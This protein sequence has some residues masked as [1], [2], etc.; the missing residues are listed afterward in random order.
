MD[1][2]PLITENKELFK[3]IYGLIVSIICIIIVLKTDRLFRLSLHNGI[4][5]FRNAFLFFGIAFFFRFILGA[6][7]FDNINVSYTSIIDLLF[8]FFLIMAG[9]F[10][11][12]SL[13]WKRFAREENK[14]PSSL[15]TPIVITFYSISILLSIADTLWQTYLFMFFSQIFLFGFTTIIS[16]INYINGKKEHKFLKFYL[17][18]MFLSLVAWILNALASIYFLWNPIVLINIYII[19][20][21]I[22]LLFLF[23]VVK[24]TRVKK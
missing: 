14:Y 11:L 23:G 5:Y 8:E 22:F 16:F 17:L 19:N 15:F 7:F 9:F 4:R 18:A 20:L 1:F 24:I 12:Y 21:I 13:L 3:I 10:L 6:P 2:Y